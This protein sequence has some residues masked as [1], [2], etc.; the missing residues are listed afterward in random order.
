LIVGGEGVSDFI[1]IPVSYIG[2]LGK[3]DNHFEYNVGGIFALSGEKLRNGFKDGFKFSW[4]DTYLILPIVNIG[5]R[6]Q[7]P[8]GGL[9]FRALVG[10]EGIS[11]GIGLPLH[12]K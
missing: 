8:T 6:F 1:Q 2:V 7:K 5:Y 11:I 10:I 3:G 9:M 4:Y 12:V